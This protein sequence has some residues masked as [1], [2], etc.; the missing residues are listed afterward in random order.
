MSPEVLRIEGYKFAIYPND[1]EPKHVHVRKAEYQAVINL[2]PG[3]EVRNNYGFR[4]KEIRRILQYI[5][6]NYEY[7][8]EK[9][10]Q[11]HQDEDDTLE[12]E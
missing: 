6:E 11:I 12:L 10:Y 5:N 1:H 2:E 3:I 7:L 8:L 9:W 4:N